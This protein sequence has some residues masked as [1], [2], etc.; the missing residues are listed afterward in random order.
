MNERRKFLWVTEPVT[1]APKEEPIKPMPVKIVEIQDEPIEVEFR[2]LDE[3]MKE[4]K[5]KKAKK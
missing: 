4:L 3:P 5:T 1:T 2:V